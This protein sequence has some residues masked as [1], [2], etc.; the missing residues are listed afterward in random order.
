[1]RETRNEEGQ[2]WKSHFNVGNANYNQHAAFQTFHWTICGCNQHKKTFRARTSFCISASKLTVVS[3]NTTMWGQTNQ[4]TLSSMSQWREK[5]WVAIVVKQRNS[6]PF[7]FSS[8]NRGNTCSFT[9]PADGLND[10]QDEGEQWQST[11]LMFLVQSQK[12]MSF[13]ERRVTENTFCSHGAPTV[14]CFVPW[15]IKFCICVFS[16]SGLNCQQTIFSI[17]ISICCFCLLS[18]WHFPNM[19]WCP[20]RESGMLEIRQCLWQTASLFPRDA[21]TLYSVQYLYARQF[22]TNTVRTYVLLRYS[23]LVL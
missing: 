4:H 21:F 18:I 20:K 19:L 15:T 7:C 14:E 5:Q 11:L 2:L 12:A 10:N 9:W 13:L 6:K 1:M 17:C 22:C 23:A 16:S 3:R 8:C